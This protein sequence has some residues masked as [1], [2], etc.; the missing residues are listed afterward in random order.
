MDL[1]LGLTAG[2]MEPT[3]TSCSTEGSKLGNA[4]CH[5]ASPRPHPTP[6]A[7]DGTRLVLTKPVFPIRAYAAGSRTNLV[8]FSKEFHSVYTQKV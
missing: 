3:A 6:H 2:L 1:V 4:I 7:N 8:V 5:H